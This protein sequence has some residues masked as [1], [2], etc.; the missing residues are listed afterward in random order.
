MLSII[1][2]Y[3]LDLCEYFI[4]CV[5]IYIIRHKVLASD[6]D[7]HPVISDEDIVRQA[8]LQSFVIQTET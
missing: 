2:H 3:V 5:L 7:D 6:V 1:Y 8:I 4:E